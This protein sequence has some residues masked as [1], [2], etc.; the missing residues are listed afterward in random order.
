MFIKKM[1]LFVDLLD[2]DHYEI[3]LFDID[4]KIY[5]HFISVEAQNFLNLLQDFH[6]TTS[7][8]NGKINFNDF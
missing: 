3:K 1:K 8:I 4:L 7:Q 5:N 2:F 6:F